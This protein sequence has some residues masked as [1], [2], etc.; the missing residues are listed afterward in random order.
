MQGL[1][2]EKLPYVAPLGVYGSYVALAICILVAL[3][4]NYDVFTGGNFAVDKYKTFIT[5]YIGIPVYLSLL[6]CHEFFT[7]STGWKAHEAYLYSGKENIVREEELFLA[8]KAAKDEAN[9]P[10][11]G[12]WVYKT[13]IS[14]LF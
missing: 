1:T 7:N 2:N 3:T 5:G 6:F 4:K 10:N 8:E 14:W 13:F 9:G 11:Q 12:A